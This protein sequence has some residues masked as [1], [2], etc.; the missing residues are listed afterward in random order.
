MADTDKTDDDDNNNHDAKTPQSPDSAVVAGG[1][2]PSFHVVGRKDSR[3]NPCLTLELHSREPCFG[4]SEKILW[5]HDRGHV[6]PQ[7][8]EFCDRL[9]D[10]LGVP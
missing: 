6:L 2:M 9:I 8:R 7:D 5:E 10:F 3:V 4:G 1:E